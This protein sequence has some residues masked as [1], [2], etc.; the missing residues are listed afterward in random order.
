MSNFSRSI[1]TKFKI[2]YVL[3]LVPAILMM[4]WHIIDNAFPAADGG[5]FHAVHPQGRGKRGHGAR[6]KEDGGL[7]FRAQ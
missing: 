7:T 5:V 2:N 6:G 1:I 4:L 3:L